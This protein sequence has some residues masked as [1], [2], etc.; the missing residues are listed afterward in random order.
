MLAEARIELDDDAELVLGRGQAVVE[1]LAEGRAAY[2]YGDD[3]GD[4]WVTPRAL[5]GARGRRVLRPARADGHDLRAAARRPRGLRPG[6]RP[7]RPRAGAGPRRARPRAAARRGLRRGQASPRPGRRAVEG[8]RSPRAARGGD[9]APRHDGGRT[10]PDCR[11]SQARAGAAARGGES[12]Q[13]RAR[14]HAHRR[15][16]AGDCKRPRLQLEQHEA[17]AKAR[18]ALRCSAA[19]AN[20]H[21][22]D[23]RFADRPDGGCETYG[24]TQALR[25]SSSHSTSMAADRK[26]LAAAFA[27]IAFLTAGP[28]RGAVTRPT[29][30]APAAGAVVQFVP[31]FAWTPVAGVEKYEFQ[32]SADAGMNSPVLGS[33]NDD[34]FTRNTRATLNEDDPERHLLLARA[35]DQRRRRGLEVDRA[36]LV[37][38]ALEPAAGDAVAGL[39]RRAHL[40][41]EPGRAQ[42][43]GRSPA[44]RTTSSRPRATRP[45]ARSSC[46][47]STR[48]TR[49]ARRTSPRRRAAITSALAPG[50]YYWSVTPGRRRGQPRRRDAGRLVQL[51]LADRRRRRSSRT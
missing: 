44:P 34:F 36:A 40:P 15:A 45:S 35:R 6:A 4:G 2:V 18:R 10:R 47:T 23:D 38:E 31:S 20:P 9:R 11:R 42:L 28:A 39:G 51:A 25:P 21:P 12:G 26:L 41:G 37:Q 46:T 17:S 24:R 43:V 13:R 30:T 50:S 14:E 5:R 32:I 19:R 29:Q 22:R 3:G 33:G 16:R 1:A 8:A 7:G 48:T 27:A 49:R